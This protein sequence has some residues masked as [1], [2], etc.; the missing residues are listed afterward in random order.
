VKALGLAEGGVDWAQDENNAK[1]ITPEM[2]AKMNSIKK[3][4]IDG[5]I[6]IH[7]YMADNTCKY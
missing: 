5:K 6:Q 4:I 7:D 1:L 3:D 2:K